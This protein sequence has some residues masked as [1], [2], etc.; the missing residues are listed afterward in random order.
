M[1]LGVGLPNGLPGA[2]GGLVVDWARRTDA[3]PYAS[4]ATIDRL[5]YGN[6]DALVSLA[7]A[8]AVTRRVRLVTSILIAP[9]RETA[10][11]AKQVA[12]LDAL[13]G[14]RVT[15]GVAVGARRDDYEA[16]ETPYAGRGDRLTRQLETLRAHWE[17]AGVEPGVGPAPA[18]DGGPPILVG[19]LSGPA[20]A[21]M[22]ALGDGYIH[23]GGPPRAFARAVD[24]ARAAWADA[25]RPGEPQVWGMAYYAL[26]DDAEAAGRAYLLDYY[27]FTGPFAR[28]VADGLLVTPLALREFIQ[29][30]ADA[31]CDHLLL[32]PAVPDLEDRPFP[33]A[34]IVDHPDRPAGQHRPQRP[35]IQPGQVRLGGRR[36]HRESIQQPVAGHDPV[37][38]GGRRR[39]ECSSWKWVINP[40]IVEGHGGRSRCC[41]HRVNDVSAAELPGNGDWIVRRSQTF[42]QCVNKGSSERGN[43]VL[44]P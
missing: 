11:L 7:A 23:A 42:R 13:S 4:V 39:Q 12:S 19:G 35:R 17:D 29:G 9:L 22:A 32:F 31:G 26:G 18:Q 38:A 25:G 10:T 1:E 27:A 43:N 6:L 15:L 3:G 2:D 5:C 16:S 40:I 44:R 28:K 14:G 24:Q 36:V 20:Y 37:H 8:A 34:R 30:Y 41:V 21:R 33:A